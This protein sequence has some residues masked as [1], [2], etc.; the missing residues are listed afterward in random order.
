MLDIF[1]D[2]F[3]GQATRI[4]TRHRFCR[5]PED[6]PTFV[7]REEVSKLSV[8][9]P[10]EDSE[11]REDPVVT[12]Y[13]ATDPEN[14]QNWGAVKK[15][16]V[17]LLLLLYT[18]S[19]Y[20]GSSLYTAS[21]ADIS[22]IYHVS[23][24]ASAVGLSIYVIGYGIGPLLWS[25]LSEIPAIGRNHPYC[26]TY[27]IFVLLCIPLAF[28]ENF[29]GVLVLRFLLGFFGSPCLA[30]AGASYGDFW[31]GGKMP[32]V[33]ALWG[34]GATL[35]PALGPV[36]G[37]FA[38][39]AKGWRWST[40]ELLWL[41][42]PTLILMLLS[43]PET[44]SSTIL[45]RRARRLQT[46]TGRSDIRSE[47]MVTQANMKPREIA[48]F[49]LVKPWEI[50]AL[51]PAVLFSTFYTA[52]IYGIY[53]SFF[54]SFPL[55]YR[56]VYHFDQGALGLA[57]LSVLTGLLIAVSVYVA[58]FYFIADPWMAK[59]D[60][61][62]PEARLWPGLIATFLIPIGL[63]IF[64]WTSRTSVPWIASMIGVAT[65]MCGVFIITQ[66]M[67]IYLPFT[68]PTYSG[69]L[70]A[71]NGFA[72]A[73]FAAGAVLFAYP[74]FESLGV[75]DGVSLLAALTCACCVGIYIL[76]YRGAAMRKRSKFAVS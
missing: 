52:L 69:S 74:M 29:A 27:I 70:F 60:E 35:G 63:F 53:Y 34:G 73:M 49:A 61:I 45:Y 23:P 4:L 13:D 2:S 3:V 36:V 12:W 32:Y 51:D 17:S 43:L 66:C 22:D 39:A 5:Y 8:P 19:V 50:N 59:Q 21:E 47:S 48:V 10:T 1:R 58:Y 41:S 44:S 64:A 11:K 68:Y 62:P 40:W 37:N 57:F 25:P 15:S 76:Y 75:P 54:E 71:A 46:I 24:V 56:D 38:V 18:F 6:D 33:I 14:P 7:L 55:V 9:R 16:W 20:I 42:G 65:S 30:T 31:S 67:F 28:V 72:R 26:F